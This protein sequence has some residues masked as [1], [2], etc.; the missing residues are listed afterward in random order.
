MLVGRDCREIGFILLLLF[1]T[2]F[3][4]NVKTQSY[5]KPL[6]LL[7]RGCVGRC[8]ERGC[9]R[10]PCITT[11]RGECDR[12]GVLQL[13]RRDVC[14]RWEVRFYFDER[15]EGKNPW[16]YFLLQRAFT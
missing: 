14:Y 16:T 3:L 4:G 9:L 13:Q 15:N 6:L 11:Q 8:E 7:Q 5:L 10:E 12:R 2:L 1:S